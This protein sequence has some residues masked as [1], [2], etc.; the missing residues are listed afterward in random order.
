MSM[1]TSLLLVGVDAIIPGLKLL[2]Q[3]SQGLQQIDFAEVVVNG[4]LA[5]LLFAG[6]LHVDLETLKSR[7]V[8]VLLLAIFATVI[9]TVIVGLAFWMV[10]D[11]AGLQVPLAWALMFGA[12]ISPTDPV[13][14][15][16]T[17]RESNV[18]TAL[19]VE[20][21]GEALFNDGVG[22]ALFTVLLRFAS[23][24]GDAHVSLADVGELLVREAGGGILLGLTTGYVAYRA[25]RLI[26]DYAVEVLISVAL[27]TGTYA[28]AHHLRVSGPLSVV[29]AGLL[30]GDR[31]PRYAMSEQTQHYL[32]ALW[33]LIDAILNSVL[34]LLIGLET[35]V[36]RF[37][38]RTLLIAITAVPIVLLA[39]FSSIVVPPVLFAW[40]RLLSLR[41]TPFLT[42]AGVRG[43]MSVAL[44]LS[45]PDTPTK[46]VVLAATYAVVLFSIIVQG[47]TLGFVARRTV[48]TDAAT[49][50]TCVTE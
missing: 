9:S 29:A 34:F 35:L 6:A 3:L 7:A 43:G 44:A 2:D 33:A 49:G 11:L 24:G 14:V 12:L 31:G 47:S 16:S 22:I 25:T 21:E 37:E 20:T 45:L 40:T 18:P 36:L 1:A 27:V 48:G 23:A 39:R 46:S 28:L 50:S 30:I 15:L 19:R 42:W 13:A 10:T 17:L 38:L 32:F 41:N 8:P 4:M 26:D 5:F